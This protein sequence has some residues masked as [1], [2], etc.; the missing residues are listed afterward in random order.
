MIRDV[1]LVSYLPTFMQEYKEPVIAL[2]TEKPE[3]CVVWKAADRVLH[4]HFISTADEYG[5]SRFEK[6][7]GIYPNTDD[8]LESRR[9]RVQ[10]KWFNQI[11]YTFRVLLQKLMALC[12]SAD[13]TVM[14]DFETGYTLTIDTHLTLFGQIEDL[15][16]MVETILPCNI[17][18]VL[19][20][21]IICQAES[22]Q[23]Y[24]GGVGFTEMY[25]I[26]G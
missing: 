15:E 25:E 20:N 7:L 22:E 17:A 16:N 21:E 11:P 2:K 1:D 3:F 5:I 8:T 6:L 12:G 19:N 24:L 13:F 23:V 10:S 14:Q 26:G 4:N 9:S 18:T